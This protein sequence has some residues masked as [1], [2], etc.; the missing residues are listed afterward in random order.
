MAYPIAHFSYSS[1]SLFH[2]DMGA[3]KESYILGNKNFK[4]SPAMVVGKMA[5]GV[6]EAL[7]K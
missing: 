4:S 7:N 6:A 1:M 2:K 5:H 3:W